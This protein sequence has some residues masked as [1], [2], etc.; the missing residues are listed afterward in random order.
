L[1]YQYS[2]RASDRSLAQQGMR[3]LA[4]AQTARMRRTLVAGILLADQQMSKEPFHLVT[5]GEKSDQEAA[6]LF[7]ECL[8]FPAA[9]KRVEWFDRK[10]GKLANTNIDYPIFKEAA[11]FFCGDN[12]CSA[13]MRD[14]DSVRKKI[15]SSVKK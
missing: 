10:E 1:L 4:S 7:A 3:Y 12:T 5:V 13:P 2:G 6:K 9:Y 14:V 8:R 11:V 15:S